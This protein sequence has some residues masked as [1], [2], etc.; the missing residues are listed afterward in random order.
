[1]S[2]DHLLDT[3]LPQLLAELDVDAYDS[4]I[5]DRT[6]F[7]AVGRRS[8]GQLFLALP[9]GR[10]DFERDTT[11]RYLLAQAFDVDLPDLP[12]PFETTR[13]A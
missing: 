5:S 11:A 4:S 9:R 10:S 6:F 7:G 3:P 2:T 12:P 1:M 13:L 8:S